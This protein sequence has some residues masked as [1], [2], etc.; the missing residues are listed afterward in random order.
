M[1]KH[2]VPT[3]G[4]LNEIS[5]CRLCGAAFNNA[6]PCEPDGV[7]RDHAYWVARESEEL[8]SAR[9]PAGATS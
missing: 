3:A 9:K 1:S 7:V 2:D 5:Y 6:G 8:E 4:T